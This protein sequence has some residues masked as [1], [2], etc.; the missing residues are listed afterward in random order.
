MDRWRLYML[1]FFKFQSKRLEQSLE[2]IH[3]HVLQA[4]IE[5]ARFHAGRLEIWNQRKRSK[6]NQ[7][8][9]V[10]WNERSLSKRI[11]STD[12]STQSVSLCW[13]WIFLRLGRETI[14]DCQLNLPTAAWYVQLLLSSFK[15]ESIPLWKSEHWRSLKETQRWVP[16]KIPKEHQISTWSESDPTVTQTTF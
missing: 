9:S 8:N 6:G 7:R 15:H 12:G 2:C 14:I 10:Q 16:I 4:I 3:R 13:H 1:P 11:T 5:W